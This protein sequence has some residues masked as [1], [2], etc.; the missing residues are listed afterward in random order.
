MNNHPLASILEDCIFINCESE[1]RVNE[2]ISRLFDFDYDMPECY[3]PI[4]EYKFFM[5]YRYYPINYDSY[6]MFKNYLESKIIELLPRFL[7]LYESESIITNPFINVAFKKDSFKRNQNRRKNYAIGSGNSSGHSSNKQGGVNVSNTSNSSGGN[8]STIGSG[9]SVA[10]DKAL[11]DDKG[12]NTERYTDSPQSRQDPNDKL[13]N[14]GYITT[15]TQTDTR[16]A[17]IDS[18][19]GETWNKDAS[20]SSNTNFANTSNYS[21]NITEGTGRSYADYYSDSEVVDAFKGTFKELD[22]EYGLKGVTV[23]AVVDEWRK[24]FINIDKMFLDE[25]DSLFLKVY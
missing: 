9:E 12:R 25:L 16:N 3:K 8:S 6:G 1:N 23:S 21:D 4:F 22:E 7:K 17:A 15:L 13:F 14:D 24:T 10:K 20:Q 19:L 5:R 18:K 11:H 2:A